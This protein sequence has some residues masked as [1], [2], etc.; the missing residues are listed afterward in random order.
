MQLQ[1]TFAKAG[2]WLQDPPPEGS[3][4]VLDAGAQ[5]EHALEVGLLQQQLSV[6]A[7]LVGSAQ[8]GSNAMD[9]LR[10][11][12]SVGVVCLAVVISHDLECRIKNNK[13]K[14]SELL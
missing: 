6:R 5:T 1:P 14:G 9:K 4:G 7:Q 12:A 13:P 3:H 10:N 11:E 8:Q 2:Q